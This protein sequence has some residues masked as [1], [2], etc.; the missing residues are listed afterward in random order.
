MTG[1]GRGKCIWSTLRPRS[2]NQATSQWRREAWGFARWTWPLPPRRKGLGCTMKR[3]RNEEGRFS[4]R[5]QGLGTVTREMVHKRAAELA[6]INGRSER[7]ILDSDWN[8]AYRELTGA[9]RL[10]P[11]APAEENL[12]EESRGTG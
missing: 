2:K 5:G 7:N 1:S 9:E 3:D 6:V 8:Q 11:E 10:V 12:P 4:E